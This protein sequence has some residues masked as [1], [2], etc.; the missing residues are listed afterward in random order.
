MYNGLYITLIKL[1][2]QNT[3]FFSASSR[4]HMPPILGEISTYMAKKKVESAKDN[5]NSLVI[6]F[7]IEKTCKS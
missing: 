1:N 3:T 7:E 2:G 4:N 5:N 6:L